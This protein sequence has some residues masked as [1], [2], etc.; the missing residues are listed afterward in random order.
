MSFAELQPHELMQ[1]VAN[2]FEAQSI[3]YRVKLDRDYVTG[4]AEKLGVTAEWA[5]AQR[6]S[7]DSTH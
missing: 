4:W 2:F 6:K 7:G 1:I 3:Q 5:L